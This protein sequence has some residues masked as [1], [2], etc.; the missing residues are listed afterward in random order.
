MTERTKQLAE[1]LTRLHYENLSEINRL[2][3]MVSNRGE[4]GV[5]LCLFASE[6]TLLAGELGEQTGLSTGRIANILRKLESK[7]LVSRV[8]DEL[9]RRCVHVSL[10][11]EGEAYA[12]ELRDSAVAAHGELLESLGTTDATEFVRIFRRC[13]RSIHNTSRR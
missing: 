7:G 1:E 13:I 3:S 4:D 2:G 10:T 11:E 9:D 8:Q 6:G 5:V 12:R